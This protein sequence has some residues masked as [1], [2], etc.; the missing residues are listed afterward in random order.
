MH[1]FQ[2][3]SHA[4]WQSKAAARQGCDPGCSQPF[5]RPWLSAACRRIGPDG[6]DGVSA[7]ARAELESLLR[8][9]DPGYRALHRHLSDALQL[10]LLQGGSFAEPEGSTPLMRTGRTHG[11]DVQPNRTSSRI[12][13]QPILP[14]WHEGEGPAANAALLR[15]AA[16]ESLSRCGLSFTEARTRVQALA[17]DLARIAA[18]AEAEHGQALAQIVQHSA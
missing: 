12:A 16:E 8:P 6:I 7:A 9:S 18:V 13:G 14:L 4:P 1:G 11:A 2:C 17:A 10:L 3:V 15:T 5:L